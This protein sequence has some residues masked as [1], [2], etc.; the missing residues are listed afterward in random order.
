MTS[1]LVTKTM[2]LLPAVVSNFSM[3]FMFS[4]LYEAPRDNIDYNYFCNRITGM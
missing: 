1:P 3:M 2:D 4:S